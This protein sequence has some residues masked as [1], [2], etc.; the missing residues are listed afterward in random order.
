MFK[1]GFESYSYCLYLIVILFK[2][3]IV[4]RNKIVHETLS[5]NY[6][7]ATAIWI[8]CVDGLKALGATI[9]SSEGKSE[10]DTGDDAKVCNSMQK[11][12]IACKSK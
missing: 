6:T 4:Y 10:S 12:A 11:Y 3:V 9:S 1:T 2:E 8:K 7:K 5:S